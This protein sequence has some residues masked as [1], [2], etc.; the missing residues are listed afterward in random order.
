MID[1]KMAYYQCVLAR[2]QGKRIQVHTAWIPVKFARKKA[3][4]KLKTAKGWENGWVVEIVG[5]GRN[6]GVGDDVWRTFRGR[7]KQ[8]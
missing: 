4:L 7:L 1:P 6:V 8:K 2:V 5:Q 3:V